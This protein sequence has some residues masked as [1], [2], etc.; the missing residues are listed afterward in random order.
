MVP[1]VS[2]APNMA[3]VEKLP[4]PTIVSSA[5]NAS[6]ATTA[7]VSMPAGNV[8]DLIIAAFSVVSGST[9]TISTPSGFTQQYNDI[10]T[11]VSQHRRA[12]LYTRVANG[13]EGATISA[14]LSGTSEWGAVA[15]RIR[16]WGDLA[17]SAAANSTTTSNPNPPALT[18][19]W[20]EM[21][22]LW[23][24]FVHGYNAAGDAPVDYTMIQQIGDDNGRMA[25]AARFLE[26]ASEDPGPFAGT[27][28]WYARTLAI[29][30]A[31]AS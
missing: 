13:S 24:A 7:S 27:N 11:N 28:N 1:G 9:R 8:G 30:P 20:E 19:P 31:P 22:T 18:P 2:G 3:S 10:P 5:A 15:L 29:K 4:F 21:Q 6:T 25:V 16:G 17:I 26:A 12:A 14:A 23:L